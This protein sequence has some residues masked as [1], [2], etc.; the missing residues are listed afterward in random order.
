VAREFGGTGLGL[1]ISKR[2]IELMNGQI[3]VESHEGRGSCFWFDVTLPHAAAA[4]RPQAAA[5]ASKD[6]PR[7]HILLAEDTDINRE[8]ACSMLESAG[9]AVIVVTDGAEAVAAVQRETFEV[10]LM[11]VQMP[12]VDG[13]EATRRIRALGGIH[14]TQPIIALTAN[15]LPDQLA[16]FGAAGMSDH[17]GKPFRRAELYEAI[18]RHAGPERSASSRP[19]DRGAP[20][21]ALDRD[22][23]GQL[24]KAIG[25][26]AVARLMSDLAR[27]LKGAAAALARHNRDHLARESHKMVAATGMLGFARLSRA[28]SALEVA[29]LSQQPFERELAAVQAEL[30]RALREIAGRALAA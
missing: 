13:L 1:A 15:V 8:I 16:A 2:L 14:A 25:K 23:H 21:A 17:L 28:C 12:N 18:D 4:L 27:E 11:D 22:I 26:D 5:L 3:G 30:G 20:E 7:L 24:G 9:H 10:V 29:C 19:L 6:T